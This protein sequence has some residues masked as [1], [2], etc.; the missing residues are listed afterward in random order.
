VYLTRYG[1]RITDYELRIT[2]YELR[3]TNYA[4]AAHS[5]TTT[6][7]SPL[8]PHL[9]SLLTLLSTSFSPLR[10]AD[11]FYRTQAYAIG[12]SF[13]P[14]PGGARECAP[15]TALRD[16]NFQKKQEDVA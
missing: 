5:P 16:V 13:Y 2:D 3:I 6:P 15:V 7:H 11:E 14:A 10:D 8:T 1:L 12:E 4:L 9:T